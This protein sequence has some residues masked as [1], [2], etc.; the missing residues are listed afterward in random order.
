MSSSSSIASLSKSSILVECSNLSF[1]VV[2]FSA[3]SYRFVRNRSTSDTTHR[4]SFILPQQCSSSPSHSPISSVTPNSS[5]IL[6]LTLLADI[7]CAL[8]RLFL[9]ASPDS[10]LGHEYPP[11]TA[12][13]RV[14]KP[15]NRQQ[16]VNLNSSILH[17]FIFISV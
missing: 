7:Q 17:L 11:I 3:Y 14:D 15:L 13:E 8:I 2:I 12:T 16:P 9:H 4:S 10:S 5:I 6:L 1:R